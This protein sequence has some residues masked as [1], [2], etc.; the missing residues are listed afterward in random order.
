MIALSPG[1]RFFGFKAGDAL[2]IASQIQ[3]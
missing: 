1:R 3:M 2:I